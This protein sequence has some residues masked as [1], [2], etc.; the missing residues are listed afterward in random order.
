MARNYTWPLRMAPDLNIF[1]SFPQP[2]LGSPQQLPRPPLPEEAMRCFYSYPVA[3][4]RSI[5]QNAINVND[6]SASGFRPSHFGDNKQP[7]F[8]SLHIPYRAV[9]PDQKCI[10]APPLNCY[11]TP[12]QVG[13]PTVGSPVDCLFNHPSLTL[14]CQ[15]GFGHPISASAFVTSSTANAAPHSPTSNDP[16]SSLQR[17]QAADFTVEG[18]NLVKSVVK[19]LDP[20]VKVV[21]KKCN[22][23][24]K[25]CIHN[26]RKTLCALCC[27]GSICEH[28]LQKHWCRLCGGG[29]RCSHGKQKSRCR[30]CG[31]S[32]YCEHDTLRFRCR[33]CKS[34]KA[35]KWAANSST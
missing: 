33:L 29:A 25:P 5:Q 16:V 1:C 14:S 12:S 18:G 17:I 31:G 2:S 9:I 7:L 22:S 13:F 6:F 27:G 34:A 10:I 26:K 28:K 32:G 30:V 8:H 11:G 3:P 35:T 15:S 23:K 21:Q 19:T 24:P 4:V 20:I